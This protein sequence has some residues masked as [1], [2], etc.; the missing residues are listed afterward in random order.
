MSTDYLVIGH[1]KFVDDTMSAIKRLQEK[2]LETIELYS[3]VPNHE[4]E[5]QLYIKRR[6]SPVRIFTLLGA[7]TG[8]FGAF[9]M[10][11]WMSV[12]WPL[13]TSAKTVISIPAF[14]VIGF[15]CTILIGAI[16]TLL[17]MLHHSRIPNLF[18]TPGFRPNFTQGTFGL[19]V[20]VSKEQ[21]DAIK[22]EFKKI[23][24]AEVEVQYVR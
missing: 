3:P 11:I 16:V 21:A 10:T 18:P 6:R 5:D 14:V 24:A 1:F 4:L 19:T 13:R 2:G 7:L 15:E 12:D 23:G 22:D 8:C 17:G 20:R 9:L